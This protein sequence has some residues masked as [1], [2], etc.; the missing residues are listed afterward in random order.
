M[1]LYWYR[2][3]TL[4]AALIRSGSV[5]DDANAPPIVAQSDSA[6]S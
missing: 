5:P 3:P 1:T 2:H 6:E 4:F